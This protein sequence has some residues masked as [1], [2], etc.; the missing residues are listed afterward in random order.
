MARSLTLGPALALILS[1]CGSQQD[2][3]TTA[4]TGGAQTTTPAVTA[5]TAT[6]QCRKVAAPAAKPATTVPKPTLRLDRSRT[7]RAVVA[8]SCGSFTIALDVRNSPKTAA[9][10]VHLAR[11]DFFDS[12]VFHRVIRGFVVQG[13]DPQGTGTGGPGYSVAEAPPQGTQYPRG[14]VAMA[15]A[16]NEPPGT[17]GSQFYVVTGESDLPPEYAVLGRVTAGMDVVDRIEAQPGDP[18]SP[19]QE[20]PLAPVVIEDV[21]IQEGGA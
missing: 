18:A 3:A 6:P 20:R 14:A 10:F 15:K 8:T 1:A 4:T 16:E 9:S 17:S 11:R 19:D 5:T 7:Y 21:T 12:T 2:G 13:G